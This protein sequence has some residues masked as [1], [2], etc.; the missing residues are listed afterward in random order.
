MKQYTYEEIAEH[1]I[2]VQTLEPDHDDIG[3]YYLHAKENGELC[4]TYVDADATFTC[5][6]KLE[7]AKEAYKN[8]CKENGWEMMLSEEDLEEGIQY[9]YETEDMKCS[10]FR[11]VVES[12]TEQVNA[13]LAEQ[14]DE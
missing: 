5:D 1:L 4:S 2:N 11:N 8:L 9:V 3:T 12:L 13:W 6:F 7:D 14:D 10:H